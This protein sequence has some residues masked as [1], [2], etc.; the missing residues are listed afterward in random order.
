MVKGVTRRVVVVR[1]PDQKY[2]E[3]AIFLLREE[4]ESPDPPEEQVLKQAQ[5]VADAYLLRTSP[6]ARWG[7]AWVP[8]LAALAGGAGASLLCGALPPG[9]T[10][11]DRRCTSSLDPQL[12]LY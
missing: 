8:A 6:W 7:R 9:E 4:A 10:V 1:A 12:T 11:R 2:F 3:Q 5:A